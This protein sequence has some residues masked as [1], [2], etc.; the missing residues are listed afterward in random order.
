MIQKNNINIKKQIPLSERKSS[1]N[2][3]SSE[4]QIVYIKPI[5]DKKDKFSSDNNEKSNNLFNVFI[6]IKR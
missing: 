2:V 1:Q 5:S 6:Q 4:E 3:N